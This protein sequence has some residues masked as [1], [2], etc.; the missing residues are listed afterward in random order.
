M[1][2]VCLGLVAPGCDLAERAERII[3]IPGQQVVDAIVEGM[4]VLPLPELAKLCTEYS[5]SGSA[6][7]YTRSTFMCVGRR[8]IAGAE[9]L[10][11]RSNWTAPPEMN[12]RE[13]HE[14]RATLW[15]ASIVS[16]LHI[17]EESE[18]WLVDVENLSR[19]RVRRSRCRVAAGK[20]LI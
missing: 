12:V 9:L 1:R 13:G 2:A 14:F 10:R 6:R 7:G 20:M 15:R 8:L 5:E 17:L 3:G 18:G 16:F 4:L 19:L 11:R